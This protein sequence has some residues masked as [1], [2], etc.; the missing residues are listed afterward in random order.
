M[1]KSKRALELFAQPSLCLIKHQPSP[2]ASPGKGLEIR[3]GGEGD[4][5]TAAFSHQ[6]LNKG[7]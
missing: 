7:L 2:W 3:N 5:V 4:T 6:L 1:R